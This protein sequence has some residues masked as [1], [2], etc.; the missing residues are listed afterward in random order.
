MDKAIIFAILGLLILGLLFANPISNLFKGIFGGGAQTGPG[1]TAAQKE[2]PSLGPPKQ[3]IE[4]FQ[5]GP[6]QEII[7]ITADPPAFFPEDE[8]TSIKVKNASSGPLSKM[9]AFITDNQGSVIN[10]LNRNFSLESNAKTSFEWDGTSEEGSE[11]DEGGYFAHVA[12][13][14][15]NNDKMV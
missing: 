3:A 7:E 5:A 14:S 10:Y 8:K 13:S 15:T 9:I 2:P 6:I 11:L 12:I 1:Q 4:K